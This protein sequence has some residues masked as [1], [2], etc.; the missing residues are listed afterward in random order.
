MKDDR[1]GPMARAVAKYVEARGWKIIVA[2]PCRIEQQVP[3]SSKYRFQFV[4]EFL[5]VKITPKSKT[6]PA[7]RGTKPGKRGTRRS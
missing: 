6:K 1:F 5:G 2:G 4:L 7:K 3:M